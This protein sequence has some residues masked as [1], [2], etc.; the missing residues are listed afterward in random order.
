MG[1]ML[2]PLSS[3]VRMKRSCSTRQ[4]QQPLETKKKTLKLRWK[5]LKLRWWHAIFLLSIA[6]LLFCLLQISL[7]PPFGLLMKSSEIALISISFHENGCDDGVE[8]CICPRETICATN[9]ISMVLLALAR[10]SA[11]F[12]YPLYAMMFLSKAHNVNNILRRTVLREWID[13][14]DMHRIHYIFGIVIGIE[15][16]CHSFFHVL[17][18]TM[19]DDIRLLWSTT[20]GITGMVAIIATPFIVLPMA[21]PKLKARLS[22]EVRKA[23]HYQFFIWCVSL[24][25]WL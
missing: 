25:I 24:E 21:V 17:R 23:L 19:S 5:K 15:S 1:G 13:F 16:V 20:T 14:A 7:P 10:C 4:L 8:R 9:N 2:T 11:F 6:S 12:D 3:K 22:F 18:W